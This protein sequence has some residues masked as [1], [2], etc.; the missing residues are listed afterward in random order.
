MP[1]FIAYKPFR[2]TSNLYIESYKS[3]DVAA[4]KHAHL[5]KTEYPGEII[6]TPFFASTEEEAK[7]KAKELLS[8]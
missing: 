3:L 4:D 2:L 6:S 5:K 8:G 1:Y 7:E